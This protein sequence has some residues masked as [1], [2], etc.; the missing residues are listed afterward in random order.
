[1]TKLKSQ[2][3]NLKFQISNLKSQI[4]NLKFQSSNFKFQISNFK[5]IL[6]SNNFLVPRS[7]LFYSILYYICSIKL[8]YSINDKRIGVSPV[9]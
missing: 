2:I 3:S 8:I 4:S 5:G 6:N 7:I 9:E 1:M